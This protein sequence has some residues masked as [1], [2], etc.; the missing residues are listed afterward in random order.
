MLALIPV[1]FFFLVLLSRRLCHSSNAPVDE[2][3]MTLLKADES[4]SGKKHL[5]ENMK[6][7]KPLVRAKTFLIVRL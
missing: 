2:Q 1:H 4:C 3:S 5:T 6:A 7:G